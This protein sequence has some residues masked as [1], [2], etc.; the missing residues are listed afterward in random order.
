M[1]RRKVGEEYD[2]VVLTNE[3]L[4]ELLETKYPFMFGIDISTDIIHTSEKSVFTFTLKWPFETYSKLTDNDTYDPNKEYFTFKEDKYT[5]IKVSES[6]FISLKD[7]LYILND[8]LD[9]VW[10]E[11]A[12][13]YLNDQ[14]EEPCITF[15]IVINASQYLE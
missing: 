12:Y 6:L 8:D 13:D 11:K 7:T 4:M 5:K 1:N 9:T 3:N 15:E 14:P 10:G 2:D